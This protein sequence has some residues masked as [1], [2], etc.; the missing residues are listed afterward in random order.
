MDNVLKD[1]T[2]SDIVLLNR[3]KVRYCIPYQFTP[4]L[5]LAPYQGLIDMGKV[6]KA[7][8][9][10]ES[11]E[12]RRELERCVHFRHSFIIRASNH[13]AISLI[14]LSPKPQSRSLNTRRAVSVHHRTP[15]SQRPNQRNLR[16]RL[17]LPLQPDP[18]RRKLQRPLHLLP[19]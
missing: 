19:D 2:V 13:D 11:D 14:D 3:A 12:E 1:S 5:M 8:Q 9:P 10:D 15:S 7:A 17:P 6:F 18:L 4:S 16:L